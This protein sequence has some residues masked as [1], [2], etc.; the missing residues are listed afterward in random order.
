MIQSDPLI[1]A[2]DA[3]ERF[4]EVMK[5]IAK[6]KQPEMAGGQKKPRWAMPFLVLN[7]C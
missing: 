2:D 6:A 4:K 3:E 7:L 5:R 1:Q